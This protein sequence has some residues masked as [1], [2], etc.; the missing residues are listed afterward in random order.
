MNQ[1]HHSVTPKEQ[2]FTKSIYLIE[3]CVDDT[4][5]DIHGFSNAST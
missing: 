2:S 4:E 3:L 1:C 5:S